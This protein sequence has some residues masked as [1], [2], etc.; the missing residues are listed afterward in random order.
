MVL[1]ATTGAVY[2]KVIFV[3]EPLPETVPVTVVL[4]RSGS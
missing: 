3:D 4:P 1:Q 2:V